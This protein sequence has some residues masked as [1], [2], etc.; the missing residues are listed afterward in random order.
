MDHT[1]LFCMLAVQEGHVCRE[2]LLSALRAWV[3]DRTTS[4]Q[5]ILIEK[6]RLREEQAAE[7][8][9]VVQRLL[10][11]A[12][13]DDGKALPTAPSYDPLFV[14]LR[15]IVDTPRDEFPT[16]NSVEPCEPTPEQETLSEAPILIQ[17]ERCKPSLSSSSVELGGKARWILSPSVILPGYEIIKP[18]GHGGMGVVYEAHQVALDR[19]VAVKMVLADEYVGVHELARFRTEVQAVARLRHANIVQIYEVGE[20]QGRPYFSMELVDGGSLK[21][22]LSGGALAPVP[23]ARLLLKLARAVHYA[24]QH[25]VMH[26]DL[27]PQNIL[28]TQ[29]GE[30]K[31][32]DFGL[33]KLLDAEGG[34]TR[35]G[36]VL[37]TPSYMAPEQAQGNVQQIGPR[38]DVYGLGAILY[39]LLTGQPPYTGRSS[40]EILN[41]VKTGW[42][43]LPS[44]LQPGVSRELEAVCLKCME[45]QP[46]DRYASALVLVNDLRRFLKGMSVRAPILGLPI[47]EGAKEAA[48]KHSTVEGPTSRAITITADRETLERAEL[49]AKRLGISLDAL[50]VRGLK[51]ILF[52]IGEI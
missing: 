27:K 34:V 22:R 32:A 9:G 33:A 40:I 38:T 4:F 51:S 35:T 6:G 17:D 43:T 42:P 26:R 20:H 23:A 48:Q 28:L 44:E 11:N 39:E 25:G 14:E 29:E 21:Q 1:I 49:L 7:L 37:G 10:K 18:L 47:V 8:E 2:E 15:A 16:R 50:V 3:S 24:H 30:P 12:G 45:R 19:R 36:M 52:L 41:R 5:Q 31:I 46:Q 13:E